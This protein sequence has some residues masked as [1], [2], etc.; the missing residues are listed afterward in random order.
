M[1]DGLLVVEHMLEID[2]GD[3]TLGI[4]MDVCACGTAPAKFAKC[5]ERSTLSR[6]YEGAHAKAVA[7]AVTT[8]VSATI[9]PTDVPIAI[10]TKHAATKIPAGRYALGTN[11][12]VMA[13]VAS[14]APIAFADEAKMPAKQ[15]IQTI[16]IISGL[17]APCEKSPMRSW[18]L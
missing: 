3:L 2:D 18:K 15:K 8:G 7:I 17:A 13:T 12:S 9:V 14:T 16:Y 11:R 4:G 10:E 5:G 6:A 1:H